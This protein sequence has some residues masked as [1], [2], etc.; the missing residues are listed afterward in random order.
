MESKRLLMELINARAKEIKRNKPV[1]T[2]ELNVVAMLDD[3][4][5]AIEKLITLERE[6]AERESLW[7]ALKSAGN[8]K[9]FG[10]SGDGWRVDV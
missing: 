10:G 3:V 9:L 5:P 4:I 7:E 8:M 2:F 1:S 6:D